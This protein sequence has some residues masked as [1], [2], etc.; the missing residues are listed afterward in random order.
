[1]V[2]LL[3]LCVTVVWSAPTPHSFL[4]IS[5]IHLDFGY[6]PSSNY[7]N[8]CREKPTVPVPDTT[9]GYYGKYG[10]DSPETLVDS[11]FQYMHKV[12]PNPDFILLGGDLPC[13]KL[14]RPE[15]SLNTY[16]AV[17]KKSA[18]AFPNVPTVVTMG[19]NDFFPRYSVNT[20]M[21]TWLTPLA[22]EMR[23]LGLFKTTKEFDTF[24]QNGYYATLFDSIKLKVISIN[25]VL[26]SP[27]YQPYPA[28]TNKQLEHL[29][30]LESELSDSKAKGESV[31]I[32]GHVPPT[33]I[34]WHNE[35]QWHPEWIN[36]YFNVVRNYS[37]EIK[38]QFYTHT[39]RDAFSF[40]NLQKPGI[41]ILLSPSISPNSQTNPSFR[42]YLFA[43]EDTQSGSQGLALL[44]YLEYYADLMDPKMLSTGKMNWKL[45]YDFN[46]AYNQTAVNTAA[47]IDLLRQIREDPAV[48]AIWRARCDSLFDPER[49]AYICAIEYDISDDFLKCLDETNPQN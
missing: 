46:I 49:Y 2:W 44:D 15:D 40:S 14:T 31:F 26:F 12:E 11:A 21:S 42:V 9:Y 48:Y 25:T 3:F 39:H 23:K 13:H 1:M 34:V 24:S 7:H 17:L 8:L 45:E 22:I 41:P 6:N 16:L 35:S 19:N 27:Y 20:T 28:P 29:F 32:M 18:Q 36:S 10:C 33:V 47:L 38:G 37:A 4:H 30:W 43:E 5:D